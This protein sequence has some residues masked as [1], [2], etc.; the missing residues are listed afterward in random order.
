MQIKTFKVLN[1]YAIATLNE[2]KVSVRS[3]LPASIFELD[4]HDL[5]IRHVT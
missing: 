2:I 5:F 1:C 3:T 4:I